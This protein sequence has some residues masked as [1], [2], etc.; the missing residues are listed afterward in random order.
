MIGKVELVDPDDSSFSIR[1]QCA[2]LGLPR[3]SYYYE[4]AGEGNLN[5][6]LMRELDELYIDNPSYGSR[7][8]AELL[9]RR[10]YT[11]N[12]KRIQRLMKLIGVEAIYP[13][14]NLSRSNCNHS[15]YPYLLREVK[16][17]RVNQVWSTDITYIPMKSGYL[18][19]VA[20]MDWYSRMILSYE[21]SNTL[22]CH[23]CISALECALDRYGQPEIFNSDQGSQFTSPKFCN[24]L[25]ARDIQI[26]MDGRGRALDNIFI[27]RVW[28]TL[29]YEE[30]YLNAYENGSEAASRIGRF[31]DKYNIARPHQ[32]LKYF[33]PHEVYF[34]QSNL[35]N[36][37][38][39]SSVGV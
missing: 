21:L 1:R 19:L 27:E 31:F 29:K 28:R 7:R 39:S 30:V 38:D 4:P 37:I 2:L 33:T 25:K 36:G 5:L 18:Y 9:K 32:S 17:E 34:A 16:I 13:K 23:F 26:S 35:L 14:R 24:V 15:I 8:L 10:D 22:D 3:S 6:E 11:V 12:R 20:V